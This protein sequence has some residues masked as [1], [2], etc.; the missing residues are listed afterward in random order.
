MYRR[1]LDLE[2]LGKALATPQILLRKR[3]PR[4]FTSSYFVQK[5]QSEE[6]RTSLGK[7]SYDTERRIDEM[8][9]NDVEDTLCNFWRTAQ[10]SLQLDE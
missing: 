3:L 4:P 7:A 2:K 10:F 9:R 6:Q 1:R 8:S 5:V